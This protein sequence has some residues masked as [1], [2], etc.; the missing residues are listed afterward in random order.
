M[1]L[2]AIAAFAVS[3][4]LV[5]ISRTRCYAAIGSDD[6]NSCGLT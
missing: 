1:R 4:E 5:A 2:H 6:S 3:V